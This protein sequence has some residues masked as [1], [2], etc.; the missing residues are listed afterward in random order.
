M[1]TRNREVSVPLAED[2]FTKMNNSFSEE[3]SKLKSRFAVLHSR[4]SSSRKIFDSLA[5]PHLDEKSRVAIFHNGFIANFEDL[6]RQLNQDFGITIDT[7]SQLIA[8]LIGLELDS[9]VSLKESIKNVV[10][11]KLMGTWKLAVMS[12]EKP[13]HLYLVKNSGEIIIG[14]LPEKKALIVC[15]EESLFKESADLKNAQVQKIPNNYLV[16]LSEDGKISM[17]KLEKKIKVER[18]PKPGFDHIF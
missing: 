13:D 18:K 4:Y 3:K 2:C 14:T 10:E 9:G 15:T 8:K 1:M 7:D 6:A 11:R 12:L 16:E 5:H 17:E